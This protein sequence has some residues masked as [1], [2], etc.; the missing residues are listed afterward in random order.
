[1]LE[2]H[3]EHATVESKKL[4]NQRNMN[5]CSGVIG[6]VPARRRHGRDALAMEMRVAGTSAKARRYFRNWPQTDMLECANA[7]RKSGR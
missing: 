7:A 2:E 4:L 1:M 5:S 3:Y 6:T